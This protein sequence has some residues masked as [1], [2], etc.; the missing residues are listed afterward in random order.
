MLAGGKEGAVQPQRREYAEDPAA[1]DV[2]R[3]FH[4]QECAIRT[5]LL[6]H[7]APDRERIDAVAAGVAASAE[8]QA[9]DDP[10]RVFILGHELTPPGISLALLRIG[11][12]P[13][14]V[15]P[16]VTARIT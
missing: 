5:G 16:S 8:R 10:R 15:W 13:I 4:R 7:P 14:A 2:R 1:A 12:T 3:R 6:L 11:S 9:G